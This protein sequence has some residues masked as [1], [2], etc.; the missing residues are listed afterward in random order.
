MTQFVSKYGIAFHFENVRK[1][2]FPNRTVIN[3]DAFRLGETRTRFPCHTPSHSRYPSDSFLLLNPSFLTEPWDFGRF[4]KTVLFFNKPPSIPEFLESV[5]KRSEEKPSRTPVMEPTSPVSDQS[6]LVLG[7]NSE[8]GKLILQDLIKRGSSICV[9][10]S[11]SEALDPS[12]QSMPHPESNLDPLFLKSLKSIIVCE[13]DSPILGKLE[14]D[15]F[16]PSSGYSRL[17]WGPLD[18]VVMGGCSQSNLKVEN[19]GFEGSGVAVFSGNITSANNGGFASV[20]TKNLD[21]PMDFQSYDG[22][23]LKI[24]G[25]GQRYK[26]MLRT[27]DKWDDI[28]Y[29]K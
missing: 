19:E 21:P 8:I 3:T 25:D 12:I 9:L 16:D 10:T 28:S 15:V 22:L 6:I 2:E 29:C 1:F 26:F 27:A 4:V 14:K 7:H 17:E 5:F 11:G 23:K 24:K 20:R 18:D 13:A